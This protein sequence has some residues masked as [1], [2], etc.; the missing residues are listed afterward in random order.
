MGSF[1]IGFCWYLSEGGH[2]S[3]PTRLFLFTGFFGGFTTF[4]SFSL[5]TMN[6]MKTGDYRLALFNILAS[7]F[8][9]LIAVFSGYLLGKITLTFINKV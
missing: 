6:L 9:G 2:F 3:L 1:L 5:E 7:N 4:S 8:I